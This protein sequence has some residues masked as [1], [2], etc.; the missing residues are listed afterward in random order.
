MLARLI[1][2]N[3]ITII[4]VLSRVKYEYRIISGWQNEAP[5]SIIASGSPRGLGG[6]DGY[7]GDVR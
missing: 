2:G 1:V 3:D 5:G 6:E 7:R 4:H